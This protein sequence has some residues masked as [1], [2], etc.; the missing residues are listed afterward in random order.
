M[1]PQSA[2]PV[3]T[4]LVPAYQPCA[5][6]NR[7]HGPPL[8]FDACHPPHTAS[9]NLIVSQG[10]ARARSTGFVRYRV[11]LGDPNTVPDEA[12]IAIQFGLTH[13][14]NAADASDYVGELRG[15]VEMRI[16]DRRHGPGNNEEG[17][18]SD[19]PFEFVAPCVATESALDGAVCSLSTTAEAIV[20]GFAT[21]GARAVHGLGQVRVFDGGPD[22]D[23]DTP[24][25]DSLFAVQGVFVP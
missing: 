17:T 12:D 10:E 25:G 6:P 21:E 22:G 23:A 14:M 5:A 3:K 4:S 15:S 7:T 1:R 8:A 16:T 9:P 24:T 19:I 20:P 11:L 2:S 13:V 18:V